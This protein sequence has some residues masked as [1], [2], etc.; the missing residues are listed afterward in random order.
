MSFQSSLSDLTK[1]STAQFSELTQLIYSKALAPFGSFFSSSASEYSPSTTASTSATAPTSATAFTSANSTDTKIERRRTCWAFNHM[2]NE[3]PDTKYYNTRKGSLE[4]RY[5]YCLK[6][7][8]LNS[9]TKILKAHLFN[10]YGIN[11]G[12]CYEVSAQK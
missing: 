12:S 5:K 2:P 1:L 11:K 3:D 7:Y 6:T 10:H 4:W 8:A 9:G